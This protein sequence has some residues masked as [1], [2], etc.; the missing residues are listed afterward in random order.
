MSMTEQL[1]LIPEEPLALDFDTL[2]LDWLPP[3]EALPGQAPDAALVA[4]IRAHGVLQPILV[5]QVDA[6]EGGHRYE[7]VEGRRRI[8]AARKADLDEIPAALVRGPDAM[9]RALTIGLHATRRKNLGAELAAIRDLVDL[10]AGED[11]IARATGMGKGTLRARL[12]LI[13]DL[14]PVLLQA[15]I[16]GKIAVTVAQQAAGCAA[17][18]QARLAAI[19]AETGKLTG[20]QV[21]EARQAEVRA[22]VQALSFDDLLGAMPEEGDP[23]PA[24]QAAQE[25]AVRALLAAGA[26]D[27]AQVLVEAGGARW[28]VWV[29]RI[30]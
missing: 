2:P 8:K 28:R 23:A 17:A 26:G 6:P 14:D 7:V 24:D 30:G 27:G 29:Q 18:V 12:R 19:F 22:Q 16:A 20:P 21:A 13:A 10:G 9:G 11:A 15:V 25:A 4:S 1:A 5:R 3:D